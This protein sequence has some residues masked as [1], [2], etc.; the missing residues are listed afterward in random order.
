MLKL[1]ISKPLELREGHNDFVELSLFYY[2][3]DAPGFAVELD[4]IHDDKVTEISIVTLLDLDDLK[5][6]HKS[7]GELIERGEVPYED[8]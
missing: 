8:K 2:D 1:M 5:Q 7:L 3:E 6:L 4:V